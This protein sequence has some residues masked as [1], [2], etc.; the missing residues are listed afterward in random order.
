MK[1]FAGCLLLL[2]IAGAA[3]PAHAATIAD[4][5][6][7]TATPVLEAAWG[8]SNVGWQ[9]SPAFSYSLTGIETKFGSSRADPV[10]ASI[11]SGTVGS[12]TLLGSG[13]FSPV[14]GAFA[15]TS[16]APVSLTAGTSYFVAFSNVSGLGQNVTDN[17]GATNLPGGLRFDFGPPPGTFDA[18][19]ET[20]VT[21]QPIINF[22]GSSVISA[23]PE[24]AT[25]AL[26]IAGF[27]LV[28][29]AL[30]RRGVARQRCRTAVVP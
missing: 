27:G 4:S 26:T 18:G 19:T 6:N 24:P 8:A 20:E 21:A 29:C 2:G 23:A 30:R 5:I 11:Y 1:S 13:S 28:G 22:L 25:W 14:G 17:A 10:V 7:P 16:F 12:L 15:G 9:Y 3:L